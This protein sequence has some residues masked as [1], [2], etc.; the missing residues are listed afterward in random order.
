MKTKE[1]KGAKA[2][3]DVS[4]EFYHSERLNKESEGRFYY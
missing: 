3:Y 4:A 2:M 1:E